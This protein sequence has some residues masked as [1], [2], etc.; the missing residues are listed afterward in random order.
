MSTQLKD[1][2]KSTTAELV[3]G[4]TLRLPGEFFDNNNV[5]SFPD[6]SYV[7]KLKNMMIQLQPTQ[8]RQQHKGR[9]YVSPHLTSCT[10]AFVR[11]DAVKGAGSF[12]K[13]CK[14]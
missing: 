2:L 5:D 3:H 4:I 14:S 12:I 9:N 10:H 1:D 13:P 7:T 6:S 11:H 8:V